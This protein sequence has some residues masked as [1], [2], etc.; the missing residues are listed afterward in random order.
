MSEFDLKHART[1]LETI[2]AEARVAACAGDKL[3]VY[4]DGVDKLLEEWPVE[5]RR[6]EKR[7][8]YMGLDARIACDGNCAKAWGINSRPIVEIET[9][10][11]TTFSFQSDDE[12]GTAP[13][14]PGTYEGDDGKPIDAKTGE[15]M[16]RWCA[17][18]CE[19]CVMTKPGEAN[20]EL[21]LPDRSK[22][23]GLGS[24]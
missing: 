13:V 21:K 11:G 22:R 14:D 8:T 18:E 6:F 5:S 4:K 9:E 1:T 7:I 10:T 3:T 24:L 12:A 20:E 15:Y 17:R 16:N 19:R 2:R 23:F